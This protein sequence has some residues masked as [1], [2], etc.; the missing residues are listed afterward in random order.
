MKKDQPNA[1][2]LGDLVAA[3]YDA[4]GNVSQDDRS[5]AVLAAHAVRKLLLKAGRMDLARR[6][7]ELQ[8]TSRPVAA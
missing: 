3:A 7:S 5:A 4:A 2:C 1:V 8:L 6:L